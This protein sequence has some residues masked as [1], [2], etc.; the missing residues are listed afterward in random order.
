MAYRPESGFYS[1]WDF[2]AEQ[3]MIYILAAGSPTHPFDQLKGPY[4]FQDAFN[5]TENWFARDVIG[6]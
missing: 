1:H 3:L 4:G 5:L 6:R 2:Y